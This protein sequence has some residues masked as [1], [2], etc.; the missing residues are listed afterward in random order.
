M[1]EGQLEGLWDQEQ[2]ATV[3]WDWQ[4]ML[5]LRPS[6]PLLFQLSCLKSGA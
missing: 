6:L 5:P 3:G 1:Q 4:A 2:M